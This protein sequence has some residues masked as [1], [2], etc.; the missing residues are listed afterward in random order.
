[1]NS[2]ELH[3][4]HSSQDVI[5][6][7][8]LED[9]ACGIY[10]CYYYKESGAIKA[11]T[12]V[13]SLI[14]HKRKFNLNKKFS[15]PDYLSHLKENLAP[16]VV[17]TQKNKNYYTTDETIDEDIKKLLPA[18]I[19]SLNQNS[20]QSC[21]NVKSNPISVDEFIRLTSYHIMSF[22]N[23]VESRFP[24]HHHIVLTSGLDSQMILLTP[25]INP[26][27]W[28]VF[29]AVPN[30]PVVCQWLKDNNISIHQL[31]FHNNINEE[32]ALDYEKK[33]IANDC[34]A[35]PEHMRWLPTL[36]KIAELHEKKCFFWS[37][38][39]GDILHT[40][41]FKLYDKESLWN[42]HSNRVSSWQ[43]NYHQTVKNFTDV[44]LLSPYHSKDIWK[45]V[46]LPYLPETLKNET[47]IR[48]YLGMSLFG[49]KVC[50]AKTN[51]NPDIYRY[52]HY[53]DNYKMY[54]K[55]IESIL[56]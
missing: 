20:N 8:I 11:S 54:L 25:K 19:I 23:A 15:P 28:S 32:T 27:N 37:G 1:M 34:Y 3:M 2:L 21:H 39:S 13:S 56:S 18:Q 12:S 6:I 33:I 43:G 4:L 47:D 41:K 46:Y 14:K 51:P 31:H 40:S 55:H 24:N 44:A 30:H 38:T 45:E 22:I 36:R 53:T 16:C 10:P 7:D 52:E 26:A 35:N 49:K 5:S 9:I 42:F 50:W 48:K 29:S 17:E